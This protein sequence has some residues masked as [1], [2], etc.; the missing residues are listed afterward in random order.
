MTATKTFGTIKQAI[1]HIKDEPWGTAL[2]NVFAVVKKN[3][4]QDKTI[5]VFSE[6]ISRGPYGL[7]GR[8][9]PNPAT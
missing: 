5:Y 1:E 9:I 4:V 2:I 6:I 3:D 8:I 7:D